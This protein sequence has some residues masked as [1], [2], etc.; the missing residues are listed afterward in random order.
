MHLRNIMS[1]IRNVVRFVRSSLA[2]AM[3]FNKCIEIEKICCKSLAC[4]DNNTTGTLQASSK[5]EKAFDRFRG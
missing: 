4:L 3:K 1:A 5:F 2:R